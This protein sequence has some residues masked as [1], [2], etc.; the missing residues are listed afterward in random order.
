M[1]STILGDLASGIGSFLPALGSSFLDA[2]L[3]L[4]FITG[5]A[6]AVTGITPLAEMGLLGMVIG[7]SYKFIPMIVG[8]FRLKVRR[9][10]GRRKRAS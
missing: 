10:R 6:G 3:A 8:W 5:E 9:G 4:F 7:A 2:F 1:L